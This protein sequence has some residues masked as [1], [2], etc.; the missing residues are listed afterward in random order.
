MFF[1]ETVKMGFMG[2]GK[3]LPQIVLMKS[4]MGEGKR[5]VLIT[6]AEKHVWVSYFS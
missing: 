4:L 3:T 2:V 1:Y 5:E 6:Q